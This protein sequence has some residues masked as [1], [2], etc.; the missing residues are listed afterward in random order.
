MKKLPKIIANQIYHNNDSIDNFDIYY[1]EI[2]NF[3]KKNYENY[4]LVDC[5]EFITHIRRSENF[6]FLEDKNKNLT[7]INKYFN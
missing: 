3:T 4:N 7:I 2:I 1:N 5:V 6:Q